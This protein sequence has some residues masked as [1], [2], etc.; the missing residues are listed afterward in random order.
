MM[1]FMIL[2]GLYVAWYIRIVII[3]FKIKFYEKRRTKT[4]SY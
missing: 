1:D 2:T 3:Y 4:T